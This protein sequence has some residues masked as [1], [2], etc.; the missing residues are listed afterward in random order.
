[1]VQPPATF[2]LQWPRATG[3]HPD[4]PLEEPHLLWRGRPR[5]VQAKVALSGSCG[6]DH[7]DCSLDPSKEF[8]CGDV[9]INAVDD[10]TA[11]VAADRFSGAD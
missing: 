11:E 8:R 5:E 9:D 1:M 2:A 10:T 7:R 6:G 4:R 3:S